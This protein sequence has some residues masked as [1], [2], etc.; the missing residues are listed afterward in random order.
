MQKKKIVFWSA[1]VYFY[2]NWVLRKFGPKS[3]WSMVGLIEI[4]Y[5]FLVKQVKCSAIFYSFPKQLNLVLC[6]FPVLRGSLPKSVQLDFGIEK[7]FALYFYHQHYLLS[8]LI[9]KLQLE[10]GNCLF[11]C[12][13]Q[14]FIAGRPLLYRFFNDR[15]K[16]L[17]VFKS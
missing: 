15:L 14:H 1:T 6:L 12:H 16:V 9:T 7:T 5:F 17:R 11:Y 8:I 13:S 2:W 4:T 3:H 10:W